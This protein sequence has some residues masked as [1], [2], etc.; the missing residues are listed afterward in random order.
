[1][2]EQ[3]III[4]NIKSQI[5]ILEEEVNTLRQYSMSMDYKLEARNKSELIDRLKARIKQLLK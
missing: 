2:T 1:M 3:D 4:A 5:I